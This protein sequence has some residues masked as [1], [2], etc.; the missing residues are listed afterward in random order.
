MVK[1]NIFGVV[2]IVG[3]QKT[4]TGKDAKIRTRVVN[5]KNEKYDVYIGRANKSH[6]LPQSPFANPFR[7]S[8][9]YSRAN[10]IKAYRQWFEAALENPKFRAAVEKLRG[11]RL[12]CWCKPKPCHGD[13]IV[14]YLNSTP[15]KH[16]HTVEYTEPLSRDLVFKCEDCGEELR[17]VTRLDS[18]GM[19]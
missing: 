5:I 7:L 4:L 2:D 19:R 17:R 6:N 9:G 10:A 18:L 11:K 8:D 16:M 15:C 14:E 3:I 12:G 13:I 1:E